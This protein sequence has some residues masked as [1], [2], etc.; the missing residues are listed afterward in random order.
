M[1]DRALL[2]GIDEYPDPVN[3]L[4]SCVADT[5]A[6]S[7]LLANIGFDTSGIRMLH[8]ADATLAATREGLDWLVEGA[9]EGDRL[10]FFQ[11]SH[12]YRYLK[13]DVMTEVL[14]SYDE[15]LEDTEL[16]DRTAIV[17]DGVLTVVLDSCHSGGMEKSFFVKGLQETVRTKV[18]TP[19]R[20][21]LL[22]RA[23]S[24]SFAR[25]LKPFGRTTL[26]NEASL[27]NN[28]A[29]VPH[30]V[31]KSKGAVTGTPELNAVL[32]TACQADQ[33]AAAGSDATTGLS[34]FTYALTTEWDPTVS[35]SALRDRTV[36]RIESLNMSQTPCVFVPTDQPNLLSETLVSRQQTKS[37]EMIRQVEE[38]LKE[39]AHAGGGDSGGGAATGNTTTEVKE[40]TTAQLDKV[41][42]VTEELLSGAQAA[43]KGKGLGFED[44]TMDQIRADAPALA[45]VLAPAVVTAMSVAG[46]GKSYAVSATVSD[47]DNLQ[48]KSFWDSAAR[49]ARVVVPAVLDELTKSGGGPGKAMSKPADPAEA[50]RAIARAVPPARAADQKFF[51]LVASLIATAAPLV[52][53]AITKDYK[54]GDRPTAGKIQ[55]DLPAGMSPS[56]KKSFWDDA[57]DVVGTALPYV[58]SAIV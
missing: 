1:T 35:V 42:A 49:L 20:D 19:P 56:E 17:P 48:D 37:K 30:K 27:T 53:D 22:A 4:N 43:G 18:F 9:A 14:C 25:A 55:V 34:A 15:F 44:W 31:P 16:V 11:S 52:I 8:N 54:P 57:L 50:Q 41:T 28:M 29:H 33:T 40:M 10:V 26:R 3:N 12:G 32:L 6:F 2:V 13:G 23:K 39:V 51:G 21:E 38:M 7:Q 47:T 36:A 58:I 46:G 45:S 5:G 24:V